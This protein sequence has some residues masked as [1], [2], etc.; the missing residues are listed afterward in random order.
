METKFVSSSITPELNTEY[1]N[2]RVIESLDLESSNE[3][4]AGLHPS[5][6]I[7]WGYQNFGNQL[8]ALTS[9][10]I[11][12]TLMINFIS[13]TGRTI[14]AIFINTSFLHP[15]TLIFRDALVDRY[16]VKIHEFGPSKSE[17]KLI[18][19]LKL[20][21]GDPKEYSKITKLQPLQKAIKQLNIS[22]LLTGV[23]SDQTDN[24]A[25]LNFIGFGND[26]EIRINPFL[27]WSSEKVKQYFEENNL[28]RHPLYFEGYESV[29]DI[30]STVAG[31]DRN[32]RNV[33]ECGLHVENGEVVLNSKD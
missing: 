21:D 3:L 5:E 27:D 18:S 1:Y 20:W 10:G 29:G 26:N 8:F 9:A 13:N 16:N 22:A 11:D 33:M 4:L 15:E 6:R 28:I 25:N 14:D 24:R 30:H 31:K 7:K 32:G 17:V 2:K 12:S 23:R 19:E